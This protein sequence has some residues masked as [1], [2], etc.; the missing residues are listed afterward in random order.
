MIIVLKSLVF[1]LFLFLF[2]RLLDYFFKFLLYLK[3]RNISNKDNV[4]SDDSKELD[5]LSM[6][7][8]DKC[9]IYVLKSDAYFYNGKV[10]CKK[11]HS[12]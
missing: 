10:Y 12:V 3:N 5:S 6:L 4:G 1:F 8:C 2:M 9:K 7:Q 11:E